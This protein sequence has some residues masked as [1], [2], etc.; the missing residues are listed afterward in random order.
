MSEAAFA[1]FETF[2]AAAAAIAA[3]SGG[4]VAAAD[5]VIAVVPQGVL[6]LT[7]GSLSLAVEHYPTL[8]TY[9]FP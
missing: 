1:A 4:S 6:D 3:E 2:D 7:S 8:L 9:F 5:V